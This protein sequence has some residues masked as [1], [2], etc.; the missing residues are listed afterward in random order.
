M[1]RAPP[2]TMHAYMWAYLKFDGS[3]HIIE[4]IYFFSINL[5]MMALECGLTL[6]MSP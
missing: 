3:S 6:P 4:T 2:L 5:L 1:E